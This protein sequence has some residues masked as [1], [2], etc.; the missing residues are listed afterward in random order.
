MPGHFIVAEPE[1]P[2]SCVFQWRL[3]DGIVRNYSIRAYVIPASQDLDLDF[4]G[5][6]SDRAP[7]PPPKEPMDLIRDERTMT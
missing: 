4:F 7:I 6:T 3:A 5:K 2:V 1:P